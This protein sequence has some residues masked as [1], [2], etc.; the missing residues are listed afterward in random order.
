MNPTHHHP[1]FI[2]ARRPMIDMIDAG[3]VFYRASYQT[4][5]QIVLTFYLPLFLIKYLF[6][7]FDLI[8]IE[9]VFNSF[10]FFQTGSYTL[11]NVA[12]MVLDGSV[13]S[14]TGGATCFFLFE[15]AKGH[16][17]GASLLIKKM[18]GKTGPLLWITAITTMITLIGLGFCFIPGLWI[19]IIFL[20]ST[21]LVVIE[22]VSSFDAIW[23]RSRYLVLSEWWRVLVYFA[24]T[25]LL[26]FV[27]GLSLTFL[28]SG[29]YQILLE[30]LSWLTGLIPDLKMIEIAGG[31]VASLLL[32]P[33]QVIFITILYFDVRSRKEGFDLEMMLQ[34][35]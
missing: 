5:T 19:G 11:E 22:N 33:M 35:I 31:A 20:F 6:F 30:Q 16:E 1:D 34:S 24:L 7:R 18:A 27:L 25:T 3:V 17:M 29:V 13:N 8:P 32:I 12:L 28:I 23:K 4:V 15:K 26:L 21:Q 9:R 14:V 10:G 2:V